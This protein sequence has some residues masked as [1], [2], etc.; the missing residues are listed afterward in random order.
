M[1]CVTGGLA[2][3]AFYKHLFYVFFVFLSLDC[4]GLVKVEGSELFEKSIIRNGA[5]YANFISP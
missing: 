5:Y 4:L 3:V 1:H 2:G